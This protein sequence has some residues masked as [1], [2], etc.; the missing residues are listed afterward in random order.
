MS[1]A[2]SNLID[3]E[4]LFQDSYGHWI[5]FVP[6]ILGSIVLL[7]GWWYLPALL[8]DPQVGGLI[9]IEP[10]ARLD[11]VSLKTLAGIVLF[12]LVWLGVAAL[13]WY[14]SEFAVTDRRVLV[15]RG[16]ILRNTHEIFLTNVESVHLHQTIPGRLL[17]YGNLAIIGNGD[18]RV[19]LKT[20]PHPQAFRR[21]V[22]EQAARLRRGA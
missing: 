3:G 13:I 4:E 16:L 11:P 20:V 9:G 21:E 5:H 6:A 14:A 2:R 15:K 10:Y 22:Q 17:G 1:Y 12:S 8:Q 18:T 19:V 7:V